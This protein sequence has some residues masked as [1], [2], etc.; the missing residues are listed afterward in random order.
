L[1]NGYLYVS[2]DNGIKIYDISSLPSINLIDTIY[3]D[4]RISE[5]QIVENL[6]FFI[7]YTDYAI[8]VLE[9]S[10]PTAPVVRNE[11]DIPVS[12][13]DILLKDTADCLFYKENSPENV[14]Y[15]YSIP[16]PGN[17]ILD[18]QYN[19]NCDGNGFIYNE[20][21]Y[22]LASGNPN[23]PDLQI[24]GGLENNAPE[25]VMTIEDFASGYPEYPRT[26]IKNCDNYLYL[27]SCGDPS[28]E[29]FDSTRF[30]E[31]EGPTQISYKFTANHS[32]L[33]SIKDDYLYATGRFSHIYIYDLVTASGII[34]PIAH[35]QDYGGSISCI[36]N[37]YNGLKYLYH[38][39]MTAFSIYAI[40]DFGVPDEYHSFNPYFNNYP[41]PF[42]TSTTISFNIHR[43][44]AKNAL[45]NIKDLTGQA[46]IKI[47]NVKGQLIKQLKIKNLKFNINE[48]VWDGK[49]EKRNQVP[50]GI[51]FYQLKLN[52][53]IIKIKKMVLMR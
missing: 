27:T 20:H 3:E 48:V 42:S 44:D 43:R 18:F 45:L 25:L 34:D 40:N 52:N 22:Y 53:E 14:L 11:I 41:N 17:Y 33:F 23:G 36:V 1:Y 8:I 5:L 15:K 35:Y 19:L 37:E 13:G 46:E 47:Y 50:N 29:P 4:H 21:F 28:G 31:I 26:L 51:Y 32:G 49:D 24:I 12:W 9:L 16:E 6:L 2:F 7:D 39:Q 30:F 10:N 38:F